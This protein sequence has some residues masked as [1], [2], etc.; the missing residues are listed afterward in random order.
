MIVMNTDPTAIL[1]GNAV[2]NVFF[3]LRADGEYFCVTYVYL[4][5]V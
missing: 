5:L 3:G 4:C 1:Q 2:S